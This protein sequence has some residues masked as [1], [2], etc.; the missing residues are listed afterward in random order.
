MLTDSPSRQETGTDAAV[1]YLSGEGAA[2]LTGQILT[3]DGGP[4][5]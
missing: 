2:S 4:S 5:V 3:I 1:V